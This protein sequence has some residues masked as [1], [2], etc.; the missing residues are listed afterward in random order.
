MFVINIKK[1][2]LVNYIFLN[3]N[4]KIFINIFTY[5]TYTNTDANTDV[6]T[7]ANTDANIDH[8]EINFQDIIRKNNF[9]QLKNTINEQIGLDNNLDPLETLT[10]VN[11]MLRLNIALSIVI[12]KQ[13]ININHEYIDESFKQ[14]RKK[15]K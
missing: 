4:I 10:T 3:F 14:A 11:K 13:L 1:N 8:N 9:N 12:Y 7:D 6:K 15:T 2:I 5:N